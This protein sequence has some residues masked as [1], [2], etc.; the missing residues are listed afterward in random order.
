MN[1]FTYGDTLGQYSQIKCVYPI[2]WVS[3]T[4]RL[5]DFFPLIW[6]LL[7]DFLLFHGETRQEN[8]KSQR[9]HMASRKILFNCFIARNVKS[10]PEDIVQINHMATINKNP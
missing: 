8:M 9:T 4:N 6:K 2:I 10:L 7:V 5:N 3:Q 1:N